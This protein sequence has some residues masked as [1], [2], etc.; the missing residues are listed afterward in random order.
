M[1]VTAAAGDAVVSTPDHLEQHR[2]SASFPSTP[3]A[4]G[5]LPGRPEGDPQYSEGKQ[6]SE[7]CHQASLGT[8]YHGQTEPRQARENSEHA[9]TQE[10]VAGEDRQP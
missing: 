4:V 6:R 9:Q 3:V 10:N 1:P 7:A 8:Q 2:E 5:E